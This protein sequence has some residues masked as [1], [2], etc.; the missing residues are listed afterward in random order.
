MITSRFKTTIR[1]REAPAGPR[2]AGVLARRE[3]RPFSFETACRDYAC[4]RD[5]LRGL[6]VHLDTK[7]TVVEDVVRDPVEGSVSITES[8]PPLRRFPNENISQKSWF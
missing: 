7:P 3:R 5:T 1:G 6:V 2:F 4:R 8:R